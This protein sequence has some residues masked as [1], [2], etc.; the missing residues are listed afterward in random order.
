MN[1][2]TINISGTDCTVLVDGKTTGGDDAARA[3]G[4]LAGLLPEHLAVL[5]ATREPSTD[6]ADV[7][8]LHA[9]QADGPRRLILGAPLGGALRVAG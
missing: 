3:A 9:G 6:G 7:Y 4:A 2:L 5:V 1:D 8:F